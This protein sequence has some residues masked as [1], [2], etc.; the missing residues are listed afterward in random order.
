[1]VSPKPPFK[2]RSRS[3][4]DKPG[5]LAAPR[6]HPLITAALD[7]LPVPAAVVMRAGEE[8]EIVV[9]NPAFDQRALAPGL[10]TGLDPQLLA[11]LVSIAHRNDSGHAV[12]PWMSSDPVKARRYD[13][14]VARMDLRGM[15]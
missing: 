9:T 3:A 6:A 15:E 1:M 7:P 12:R 14:T 2:A 13:V 11:D 5:M 10:P 4:P 8:L